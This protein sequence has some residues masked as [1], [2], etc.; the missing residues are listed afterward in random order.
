MKPVTS[1]IAVIVLV[2]AATP[3]VARETKSD[4][5]AVVAPLVGDWTGVGEGQ[6]GTSASER[7]GSRVHDD[8]YVM[9][10]GRSVYP[11]QEKNKSGEIHTSVEFWSYDRAR[12]L[13]VLRQ[14]DNLG[15]VSTYLQ[16]RSAGKHG[17]LVMVSEHL[18]NVPAGWTA[19]YTYEFPGGNEYRE[20]FELNRNGEGF[21]P[22]VS[23]RFLRAGSP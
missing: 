1:L 16:D 21:K 8:K 12:N 15:F 3:A 10:E 18:E 6:P 4:P 2:V 17:A 23:G 13:L 20:L 19:R 11:K 7:H 22:Y 5:L 14:F 9:V